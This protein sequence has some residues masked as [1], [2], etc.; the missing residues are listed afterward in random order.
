MLDGVLHE[1]SQMHMNALRGGESVS[2]D[3]KTYSGG[4]R[5]PVDVQEVSSQARGIQ[6][7]WV[8]ILVGSTRM[9]IN[10]RTVHIWQ[11]VAS[12]ECDLGLEVYFIE[13]YSTTR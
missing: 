1:G 12:W 8:L 4:I 11:V 5:V 10:A 2:C 9:H 6:S 7:L 13:S 3:I